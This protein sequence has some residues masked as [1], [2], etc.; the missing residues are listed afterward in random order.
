ML[1]SLSRDRGREMSLEKKSDEKRREGGGGG[2]GRTVWFVSGVGVEEARA[3][4]ARRV[5]HVDAPV[6]PR[7]AVERTRIGQ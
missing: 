7:L 5:G 1:R 3:P 4:V 2:G 6:L